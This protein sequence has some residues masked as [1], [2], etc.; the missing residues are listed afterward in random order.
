MNVVMLTP[1]QIEDCQRE[2][3][4][5]SPSHD[6][7]TALHNLKSAIA[8]LREMRKSKYHNYFLIEDRVWLAEEALNLRTLR[9]DVEF[10]YL[11]EI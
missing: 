1:N 6:V 3:P 7:A 5:P 10:D 11:S 9:D 2:R 4:E 8:C